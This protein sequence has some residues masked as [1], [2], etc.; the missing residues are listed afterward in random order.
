MGRFRKTASGRR[1]VLIL[2]GRILR[3]G[4]I[5]AVAGWYGLAVAAKSPS[6]TMLTLCCLILAF[7]AGMECFDHVRALCWLWWH[8]GRKHD[9]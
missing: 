2:L 8:H 9:R 4:V 6:G 5:A 3:H 1:R 7:L